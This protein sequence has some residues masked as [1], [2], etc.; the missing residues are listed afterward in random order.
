MTFAV[1]RTD[2]AE[3]FPRFKKSAS[4]GFI[5]RIPAGDMEKYDIKGSILIRPALMDGKRRVYTGDEECQKK[6]EI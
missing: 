2:V 3:A 1:K 4:S 6:A 5:A